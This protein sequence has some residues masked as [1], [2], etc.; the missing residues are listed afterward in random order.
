MPGPPKRALH[1]L[2]LER[3]Y[4]G[5]RLEQLKLAR[6]SALLIPRPDLSLPLIEVDEFRIRAHDGIRL[7][8]LRAQT[9]LGSGLRPARI[10]RVGTCELPEID[11]GFIGEGTAEF[12]LLQPAGRK[13]EDRVLDL[14]RVYQL[15]VSTQEI[16]PAQVRLTAPEGEPEP[17]EFLIATQLL[18]KDL[19]V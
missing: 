3:A 13:L 16:D 8:G 9:R 2:L 10:R 1:P 4:W 18:A 5:P 15:A 19:R 12:V 11:R 14:L 7:F 17:D 6:L